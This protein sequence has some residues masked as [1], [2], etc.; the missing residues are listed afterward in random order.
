MMQS[1]GVLSQTEKSYRW[2][3]SYLLP[4]CT[5]SVVQINTIQKHALTQFLEEVT[6]ERQ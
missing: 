3:L 4:N 2:R 5:F 1:R 6:D